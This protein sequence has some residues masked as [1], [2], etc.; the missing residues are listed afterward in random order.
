M[1]VKTVDDLSRF[2]VVVE[3]GGECGNCWKSRRPSSRTG[4]VNLVRAS[5]LLF[6]CLEALISGGVLRRGEFQFTDAL[7]GMV[8][9]GAVHTADSVLVP[10]AHDASASVA[11][12]VVGPYV[13][14]GA[15]GRGKKVCHPQQHHRRGGG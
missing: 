3:A 2:G 8:D 7:Q 14:I 9:C 13:S 12:S 11:Q 10:R 1:G 15:G 4:G 5:D 6:S